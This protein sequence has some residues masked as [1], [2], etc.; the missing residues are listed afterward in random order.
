MADGDLPEGKRQRGGRQK[1]RDARVGVEAGVHRPYI[2]RGI[3]TYDILSEESLVAIETTT[4][5]ILAEIGIELRDDVEAMQ[6]Y[7]RAGAEVTRPPR[8]SGGCGSSPA[9]C[10]RS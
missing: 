7:K 9:C 6:L 1:M 10:A 3:P 2:V 4:D 8:R 5:R